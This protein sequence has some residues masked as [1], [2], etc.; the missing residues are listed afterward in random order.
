MFDRLR[1]DVRLTLRRLAGDPS[2]FLTG[3]ATLA[4][5]IGAMTAIASEF[6]SVLVE[7]WSIARPDRVV[8][9]WRAAPAR[10]QPVVE[11]TYA[12]YLA[13]RA[14][15]RSFSNTA[16]FGSS[17]W[18]SVLDTNAGPVRLAAMG[19]SSA[20]F[21]LLDASPMIGAAFGHD[22]DG[23]GATR[24]A[25]LAHATWVT[26]FG[27]DPTV[28]GKVV[29]LDGQPH[30]VVG[31]MPQDFDFPHGTEV[32]VPVVPILRDSSNRWKTDALAHAGV[33][34]VLGRLRDGISAPMAADDLER[35]PLA[36]TPNG[37]VTPGP[38]RVT[39]TSLTDYVL[40]PVRPVLW[41]LLAAGI[42]LVSIA[43]ANV[44]ALMLARATQMTRDAATR[45]AL[46]ATRV[47]LVEQVVIEAV[48]LTLAGSAA[49][50]VIARWMIGGL[51]LLAP[52]D[53]PRLAAATIDLGTLAIAMIIAFVAAGGSA[54]G[55]ILYNSAISVADSLRSAGSTVAG[56]SSHAAR[57]HLVTIQLAIAVALLVLGGLMTVSFQ[58]LRALDWGFVPFDVLTLN[59]SRQTPAASAPWTAELLKDVA[60]LPN[61]TSVG[62]VS[63]RPVRLGA[64]GEETRVTTEGGVALDSMPQ[65]FNLEVA[66]PGYFRT[67]GVNLLR[68]RFFEDADMPQS[69]PVAIVSESAARA[70]W[71]GGDP[72]GRHVQIAAD[73]QPGGTDR[74]PWRTVVGV[75]HDVRYRGLQDMRLDVYEPAQQS[76]R[77]TEDVVVRASG[78]LASLAAAIRGQ[79]QRLDPHAIVDGVTTMDA[80][81]LRAAAPWRFSAWLFGLLAALA[82]ALAAAGLLALLKLYASERSREF[83]VRIAIGAAPRDISAQVLVVAG[84]Q[85]VVGALTGG[86][87]AALVAKWAASLL[88]GVRPV[89]PVVY[90][91]VAVGVA[92]V[93]GI[94]A[95]WPARQAAR[96]DP[97]A[98]F[99]QS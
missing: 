30:T 42:A 51:V 14:G 56:R 59:V 66:T 98:L 92:L 18:S 60:D 20:F 4:L 43:C 97:L 76:F 74:G 52:P 45:L 38:S 25:V 72:I 44:S 71:P 19:V 46:G 34:F 67:L 69:A 89:D 26:R 1:T 41:W 28:V 7:S 36:R 12:D 94:A 64:I 6:R 50:L 13:W 9:C 85:F 77:Q 24:V 91:V 32:W 96:L 78:D 16:A 35:I 82:F 33:L 95:Y 47:N 80:V 11:V 99:R 73:A 10:S 58:Q 8:V 93:V 15:N 88:F 3:A 90:A 39:T 84:K 70:L 48:V 31:V 83:A 27:A 49:G 54:L 55:P 57:S 63:V 37:S 53:L 29:R 79:V 21:D 62:A 87:I 40:G 17:T 68:G 86:V 5:S 65:N 2:Y 75:V 23:P 22:V 81:V 61:V